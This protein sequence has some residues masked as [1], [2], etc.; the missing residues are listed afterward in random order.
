MLNREELVALYR[1]HGGERVLSLYLNAEEHDPAK[2]RAW[3]RAL[4]QAIDDA[5]TRIDPGEAGAFDAALAHL[6]LELKRH[7]DFLPGSGW[8]GFATPSG[9]IHAETLPV[10]MPDLARWEDGIRVAPYVRALERARPVITVLADGRQVRL[11]R[12]VDGQF[13]ELPEIRADTFFGDLTDVNMSKR[14][15][16]RTGVRG[17]TDTDTAQ[18]IEEVGRDRMLKALLDQLGDLANR[19]GR[20]VIGGTTEITGQLLNRLPRALQGRTIQEPTISFHDS[21]AEL[22]RATGVAASRITERNQEHLLDEVLDLARSGGRGCLGPEETSE[23]LR[24]G[25]VDLLL[26]SRRFYGEHPEFSDFYVGSAFEQGAEVEELAGEAGGRLDREAGG[27]GAR[28]RF[29][30]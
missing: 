16:T 25:R 12:Q 19:N 5:K 24:E 9:L 11:F 13:V 15:T 29:T 14:A 18:R 26:L 17:V 2:R 23:S 27:V 30:T 3:R 10:V 21:L 6:K 8:A 1:K 20:V 4:D 7:D 22:K 28:L